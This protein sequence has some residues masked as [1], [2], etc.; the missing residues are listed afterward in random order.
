MGQQVE[1]SRERGTQK[2]HAKAQAKGE[3][4]FQSRF[5]GFLSV[6]VIFDNTSYCR[7]LTL[8]L[9]SNKTKS[10]RQG[11]HSLGRRAFSLT[12]ALPNRLVGKGRYVEEGS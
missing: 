11:F 10:G 2:T 4:R 1:R 7:L 3:K 8:Y 9:L 5:S 6:F 12:T